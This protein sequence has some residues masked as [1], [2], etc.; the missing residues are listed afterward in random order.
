MW[1]AAVVVMIVYISATHSV[2]ID[3]NNVQESHSTRNST[4]TQM[5][6]VDFGLTRSI[7]QVYIS[8]PNLSDLIQQIK[9]SRSYCR[10]QYARNVQECTGTSTVSDFVHSMADSGYAAPELQTYSE[11]KDTETVCGFCDYLFYSLESSISLR[12]NSNSF[13]FHRASETEHDKSTLSCKFIRA[14]FQLEEYHIQHFS[15]VHV[16]RRHQSTSAL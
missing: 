11:W 15:T 13:H 6:V 5:K 12:D 8:Y 2:T 7:T 16:P 1:L 3:L 9:G 4:H 10:D 14:I